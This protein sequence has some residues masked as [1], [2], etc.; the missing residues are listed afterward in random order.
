MLRAMSL[1]V[2]VAL[3]LVLAGAPAVPR[4]APPVM[5]LSGLGLLVSAGITGGLGLT[6]HA[7]RI[8]I[9]RR[10]CG[11]EYVYPEL[12]A[13]VTVCLDESLRY[14]GYSAAAPLLNLAA[15]GLAAGGGAVRGRF[16]AWRH[17][18]EGRAGVAAA[19]MGAGAGLLGLGVLMYVVSRIALWRD[20]LGART[21]MDEGELTGAC[22]R[23]RWSAWLALTAAGQSLAVG[24]AGLLSFGVSYGRARR[25]HAALASVRVQPTLTRGHVGL[26]V[27]GQF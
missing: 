19:S 24:G 25:F 27:G 7:A 13:T 4:R 18:S 26:A 2:A 14:L 11:G 10:G 8:G 22:V 1:A 20:A 9:L 23:G 6:A 12:N 16:A 21:C 15:L 5:P 17:V 3:S